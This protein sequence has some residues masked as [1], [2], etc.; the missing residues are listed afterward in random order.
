MSPLLSIDRAWHYHGLQWHWWQ[1]CIFSVHELPLWSPIC[2][3]SSATCRVPYK[4][5]S[6][7]YNIVFPFLLCQMYFQYNV[8]SSFAMCSAIVPS[9]M[10]CM[11]LFTLACKNSLGL[12]VTA[13]HP[14]LV[15]IQHEIIMASSDT[16]GELA[17]SL[18]MYC[19]CGLLFAHLLASPVPSLFPW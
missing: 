17:S 9:I 18:S 3:K 15:L 4:A 19:N 14:F 1:A 16:V 12:S 6:F 10:M 7:T 5:F 2:Q 13:C 8:G 11:H